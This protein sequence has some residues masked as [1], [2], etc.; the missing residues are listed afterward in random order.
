[1]CIYKRL[2]YD[3]CNHAIWAPTPFRLCVTARSHQAGLAASPCS[4]PR[5]HPL[6]T[7]KVEGKCGRCEGAHEAVDARLSRA[8]AIISESKRTLANAGERCRAILEDAGID[9]PSDAEGELATVEE[10]EEGRKAS[11]TQIPAG[12][13]GGENGRKVRQDDQ[14]AQ[15]LKRRRESDKANLFMG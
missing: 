14:V 8:K 6:A 7:V 13:G 3:A 15:F 5:C 10:K 9:L 11:N 2:I 12:A 1:M 4:Q